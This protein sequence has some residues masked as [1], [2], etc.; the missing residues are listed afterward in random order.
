MNSSRCFSS[1][2]STHTSGTDVVDIANGGN[3]D[4]SEFTDSLGFFK[5]NLIVRA[6][7]D[8][9][10]S[11]LERIFFSSFINVILEVRIFEFLPEE[12]FLTV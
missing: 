1:E 12:G 2:F 4:G 6:S 3:S 9:Q 11:S 7:L 8:L 10:E 5:I